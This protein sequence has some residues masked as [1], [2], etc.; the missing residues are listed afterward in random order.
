MSKK[1]SVMCTVGTIATFVFLFIVIEIYFLSFSNLYCG[2]LVGKSC[3]RGFICVGQSNYPDAQGQCIATPLG[4]INLIKN[5]NNFF[6]K[7]SWSELKTISEKIAYR[8]PQE[9]HLLHLQKS[10]ITEFPK[11]ILELEDLKV[12]DLSHNELTSLPQGLE[13]LQNLEVL[14]LE[15]NQFVEFPLVVTKLPSLKSL[16]LSGNYLT[17]VSEEIENLQNL[18]ILKL[19]RNKLK[20]LPAEIINLKKLKEIYVGYNQLVSLPQ[21]LNQVEPSLERFF[22]VEICPNPFDLEQMPKRFLLRSVASRYFYRTHGNIYE[23]T[24]IAN[25]GITHLA[26]RVVE[27]FLDYSESFGIMKKKVM[28]NTKLCLEDFLQNKT[29]YEWLEVGEKRTF[30]A[31]LVEEAI[32]SCHLI[33]SVCSSDLDFYENY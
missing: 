5:P 15:D 6:P 32:F 25:E 27:R 16:S 12:L 10:G 1:L 7:K 3:P 19:E 33:E 13:K 28:S 29:G 24:A 2:G 31:D 18:K 30:S 14:Y 20:E 17:R 21:E 11:E 4:I 26:R 8:N 9:T 22:L 23:E